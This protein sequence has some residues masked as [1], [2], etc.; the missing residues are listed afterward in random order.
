[1]AVISLRPLLMFMVHS[2]KVTAHD[3]DMLVDGRY[4]SVG[5]K[6]LRYSIINVSFVFVISLSFPCQRLD[7]NHRSA[8]LVIESVS[9][10]T[11]MPKNCNEIVFSNVHLKAFV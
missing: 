7:R 9:L 3:F 5:V 8:L 1:M 2:A 6:L 10:F 4:L 11:N